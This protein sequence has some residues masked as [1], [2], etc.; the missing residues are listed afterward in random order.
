MSEEEQMDVDLS[1]SA[2]DNKSDDLSDEDDIDD[3]GDSDDSDIDAEVKLYEK[4]AKILGSIAE[5]TYVY[6]NYVQLVQ[7]AQ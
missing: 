1:Q 3:V 5:Q 7:V 6:D 2:D 4:Y